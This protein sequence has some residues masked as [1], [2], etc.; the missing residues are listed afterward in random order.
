M[1]KSALTYLA[2]LTA[3]FLAATGMDRAG[4]QQAGASTTPTEKADVLSSLGFNVT[5]GA[6]PGY[7]DDTA[8]ESC[9]QDI[10]RSYQETGMARSF[11]KA[12]ANSAIEDFTRNKGPHEASKRHYA[13][14]AEDGKY[15]F[16][17]YQLDG[18][19]QQINVFE[20]EVD[21][22][23]GSGSTFRT[24]LYQTGAGE[25]YQLP[26]AYYA[27]EKIWQMAP[28]Y[29]KKD[30]E[31][32]GRRVRRECMF[33]HNGYPDVPAG[34]DVYGARP[35]YPRRVAAGNRLPALPRPRRRPCKSGDHW[36]S[37][38]SH[39][40][41]DRQ[42]GTAGTET[43]RR[44]LRPVSPAAVGGALRDETFRARRL[45]LSGGRTAV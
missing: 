22:I 36:R 20:Q 41:L 10:F 21:W 43:P 34:S 37:R 19:N 33:C 8:C 11:S 26:I 1:S 29:D 30:H 40:N 25:L 5:N 6:A 35:D 9:H 28:G 4:A 44:C 39:P 31:G 42:S 3:S 17:R 14:V 2:C 13:M 38:G 23:L 24:Y 15:R 32:V 45:F 27:Q 16:R 12:D 7:V 18:E